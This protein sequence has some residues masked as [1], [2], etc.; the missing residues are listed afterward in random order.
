MG[1]K[2]SVIVACLLAASVAFGTLMVILACTIWFNFWPVLV[3]VTFIGAPIPNLVFGFLGSSLDDR[4]A[5]STVLSG[6]INIGYFLT[7]VLIVSGFGMLA[8]MAHIGVINVWAFLLTG[9]GGLVI[10]VSELFAVHF[11]KSETDDFSFQSNNKW[12]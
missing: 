7:S 4:Y 6:L 10:Y 1:M 11:F 3:L 8:V 12:F 5:N 2:S 9:F